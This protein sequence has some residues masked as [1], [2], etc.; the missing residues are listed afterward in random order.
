MT[1]ITLPAY[2]P[3]QF[4]GPLTIMLAAP[5]LAKVIQSVPDGDFA[6]AFELLPSDTQD[7]LLR[8]IL[9]GKSIEW[10]LS[11]AVRRVT[12]DKV[13]TDAATLRALVEC[14]QAVAEISEDEDCAEAVRQIRRIVGGG[15]PEFP[16]CSGEMLARSPA[17]TERD[18]MMFVHGFQACRDEVF[19]SRLPALKPG[20]VEH[21][22]TVEK[23]AEEFLASWAVGP[24]QRERIAAR[25]LRAALDALRAQPT[26]TE[27]ETP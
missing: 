13:P 18:S 1:A 14:V 17:I 22:R 10:M 26:P 7:D 16:V 4:D 21:L 27:K 8:S 25:A 24:L 12:L 2:T 23:C 6:D 15:V 5:D 9:T 19:A 20:E 3:I 11:E